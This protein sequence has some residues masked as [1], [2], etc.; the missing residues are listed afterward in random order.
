MGFIAMRDLAITKRPLVMHGRR[1]LIGSEV[2]CAIGLSTSTIAR[3]EGDVQVGQWNPPL[4]DM[5][6][7]VAIQWLRETPVID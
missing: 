1:H 5:S 7:R 4:V 2:T 6:D 3:S